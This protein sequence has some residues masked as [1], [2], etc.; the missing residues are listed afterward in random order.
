M[1]LQKQT[2]IQPSREAYGS[3]E[4]KIFADADLS[5]EIPTDSYYIYI[6]V[7]GQQSYEQ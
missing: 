3:L 2:L 4:L 7:A 1:L 5:D 6:C